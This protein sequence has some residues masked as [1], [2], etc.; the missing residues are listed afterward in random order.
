MHA[1]KISTSQRMCFFALWLTAAAAHDDKAI[2][3]LI[4][5]KSIMISF[6]TNSLVNGNLYAIFHF[7]Q[8]IFFRLIQSQSNLR[9]SSAKAC[10][11]DADSRCLALCEDFLQQ[12]ACFICNLHLHFPFPWGYTNL[13]MTKV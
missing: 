11:K 10:K 9:A 3:Q 7:Y 8:V 6:V 2:I 1:A 13:T 12:I 4:V 5:F